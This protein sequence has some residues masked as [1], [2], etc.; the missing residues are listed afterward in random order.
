[1]VNDVLDSPDP[2]DIAGS[3]ELD[4]I[5]LHF[6]LSSWPEGDPNPEHILNDIAL[7]DH[8]FLHRR[9]ELGVR[10]PTSVGR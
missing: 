8:W 4:D 1:M 6:I 10:R 5:L 2:L 3:G 9:E 7:T